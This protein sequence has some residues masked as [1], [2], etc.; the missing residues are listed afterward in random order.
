MTKITINHIIRIMSLMGVIL[1]TA[2]SGDN[3]VP[4][5]HEVPITFRNTEL[6]PQVSNRA[7]VGLEEK[8]I[9][10]FYVW[11]YKTK[12]YNDGTGEYGDLQTI[13]DQYKVVWSENTAG[14]TTSNVAGWEYVGITDHEQTQNIKY[15]DLDAT[16]YRFFG[17]APAST[18]GIAYR[19][20]A[21]GDEYEITF[22]AD[23]ADIEHSPYISK[24]W[25]T[26]NNPVDFPS[27]R[28]KDVVTMEFMKPVTKVRIMLIN[29]E[30]NLIEDPEAVGVTA[31]SFAPTNGSDIIQKGTLKVSYPMQGTITFTQYLP[32]LTIVGSTSGTLKMNRVKAVDPDASDD[33]ADWYYVLPHIEQD[34]YQLNMNIGGNT[35]M[36]TV[37]A[38]FMTWNPNMEYTYKFKLTDS[39]VQFIDIVQIAITDWRVQEVDYSIYNW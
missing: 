19:K 25:I 20:N 34:A 21:K 24:L 33:Y 14:S 27:R 3:I 30:G 15:W 22:E 35:R 11:G 2:C 5:Q 6:A 31:L 13:M 12:S 7:V 18:T 32:S 26:N 16:S 36:A 29:E 1:L 17:I 8:G 39:E 10:D 37:P 28:Y 38:K 4:E 9:H 23:A